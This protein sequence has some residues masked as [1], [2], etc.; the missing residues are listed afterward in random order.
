MPTP[1]RRRRALPITREPVPGGDGFIYR[2]HGRR[3]TSRRE[4][5][6]IAG[7]VIPPAWTQV[8]ICRSPASE[9]QARGIDAAGRT[10]MIYHP[11]YRR[12][13]EREK[14]A[15]ALRFSEALPRLRARIDRDLRG[16][17]L[18]RERVTAAVLRLI[19]TELFRVGNAEYARRY[20]SYGITTLR[21]E[22]VRV[23]SEAVTFN[24]V[25]K[26]GM[27]QV[28][29]VQDPRLARLIRRLPELPGDEVF[30]YVD[31][32]GV[33]RLTSAH[34]NEAVR[35]YAG[36]E[37]T[38][39]DFRTWGATRYAAARA[40]ELAPADLSTPRRRRA[41]A[42]A[43]VQQTALRLGNTPA[44]TRSS[45]IDPRVFHAPERPER[46]EAVRTLRARLRPR[47]TASVEEQSAQALLRRVSGEAS[48]G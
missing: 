29:R 7:M 40:L 30:C 17:R 38:A 10:Q 47:R 2:L 34:V 18:S 5:E 15:R 14:F 25:G 27:R 36:E 19:D 11:A 33:H 6:R 39:K 28:R 35:R 45:Y 3:V 48:P 13:R 46:L 44:V 42:R 43:I 4:L 37:F 8:E 32:T 23:G 41:A 22:H 26:S 24:F 9:V 12:R 21:A 16:R 20:H 1:P 31:D